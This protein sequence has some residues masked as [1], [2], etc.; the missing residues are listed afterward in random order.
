MKFALMNVQIYDYLHN[1]YLYPKIRFYDGFL[2]RICYT[3]K[4][5]TSTD[6]YF[7]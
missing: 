6:S 4:N 2:T 1:T 3:Q 5:N 7:I